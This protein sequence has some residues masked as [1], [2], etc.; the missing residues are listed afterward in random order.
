MTSIHILYQDWLQN[1][2]EYR[3]RILRAL[4]IRTKR[5][6]NQQATELMTPGHDF[7]RARDATLGTGLLRLDGGRLRRC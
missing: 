5:P 7:H 2:S 6:P 1:R 3:I 4:H